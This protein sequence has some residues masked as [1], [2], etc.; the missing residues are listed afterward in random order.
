VWKSNHYT[1]KLSVRIVDMDGGPIGQ[2][3]TE[4]LLPRKHDL[5]YFVTPAD[6]FAN[7]AAIE[8]DVVQEG[9][10]AAIVIN[11]GA[12]DA[13]AAARASGDSSYDGRSAISF[14]Y[15]QARNELAT[16]SYLVPL[17]SAALAQITEQLSAKS[18]A[19]FL[20]AN[21]GNATA[22]AAVARAPVTLTT[23]I[24]YSLVNLRPY[25][26]PVAT[27]ITLVGLIYMLIFSFIMTMSNNACREII[28]PYLR[29][30]SYLAYRILAPLALYFPISFLFS[31]INLPFKVHF[32]AHFTYAGGFFLWWFILYL[33]MASVGFATEFAITILGPKFVSFFLIPL[34]IANVSGVSVPHELQPW[35]FRYSVGMPFYNCSRAVRTI[36]FNTKN[37]IGLN[38]GILIAWL[39]VSMITIP[40]VTWLYRRNAVN[41]YRR[42]NRGV[43]SEGPAP[44]DGKLA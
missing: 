2:A 34:I 3:V 31:M 38:C 40:L 7:V 17:G 5:G 16:G 39:A 32:D 26:Q 42:E 25:N 27:A 20:T 14:I 44:S 35:I 12:S 28:A 6:H 15:A 10:W 22:I 24:S 19:E 21:S 23:P 33:G 11:A 1:D 41:E 30:R 8:H 9:S 4:F 43:I 37:D 29:T 18:V 13:V 36:I